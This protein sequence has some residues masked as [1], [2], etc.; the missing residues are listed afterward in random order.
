M[1]LQYDLRAPRQSSC[2][3]VA[4]EELTLSVRVNKKSVSMPASFAFVTISSSPAVSPVEYAIRW[5]SISNWPRE[6]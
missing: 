3:T 2:D 6:R 4:R 5:N 1:F